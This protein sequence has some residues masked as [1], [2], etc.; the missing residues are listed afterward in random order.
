MA[1]NPGN[2]QL[3]GALCSP[4]APATAAEPS[5]ST[6]SAAAGLAAGTPTDAPPSAPAATPA[7]LR[8]QSDS[9]PPAGAPTLTGG[10]AEHRDHLVPLAQTRALE[11]VAA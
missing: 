8:S 5:A 6:A 11:P 1:T 10:L 7:M 2:R 3:A 4:G 9:S